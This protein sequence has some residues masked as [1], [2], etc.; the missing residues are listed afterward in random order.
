MRKIFTLMMLGIMI[1]M[2]ASAAEE[3]L[4]EGDF[5]VTWAQGADES[6]KEWGGYNEDPTLN[7]DIAYHLVAGTKI[8]VYLE[9]NDMKD[10]TEVY[11]KCQFDNWDWEPLPGLAAI[12]FSENQEVTIEVTDELA[13]AVATKGF[14]LHGHGFNVV[15]VTKVVDDEGEEG[16]EGEDGSDVIE[17]LEPALL[18]QGEA[19][20]DGWGASVMMVDAESGYLDTF[21]EKLTKACNLYFLVENV[22][23]SDFRIAGA[24]GDWGET[25]YPA[26]EYN[27]IEKALDA[28]NVVKVALDATFVK[29]A[30][31]DK[32]G[33][34]FWGNG[35]FKILAIGTTKESVLPATDIN[36]VT[37][38]NETTDGW[39]TIDG[40]KLEGEPTTKGIYIVNGKKVI[41]K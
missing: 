34:A 23:G 3:T 4:W 6:H 18:W 15:K 16:E 28:D 14:R 21:A 7:Q 27:H 1:V 10:G 36:E 33:V 24:W 32:G 25:S 20:I 35:G 39:Y 13:A 5:Y 11:H 29:N 37:I 8:K 40:I 31:V 19:V 12:E 30:F 2:N 41:I 9:V 17:D 26:N 22:A 38:G